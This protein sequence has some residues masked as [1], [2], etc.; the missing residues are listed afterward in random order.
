MTL[1]ELRALGPEPPREMLDTE[2]ARIQ[3]WYIMPDL[4]GLGQ[5]IVQVRG[6]HRCGPGSVWTAR[7]SPNGPAVIDVLR[8]DYGG[9]KCLL[10]PDLVP[11]NIADLAETLVAEKFP[12]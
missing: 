2:P 8:S 12:R 10:A 3:A 7:V 1:E 9:L 5:A 6:C 4:N 11:G